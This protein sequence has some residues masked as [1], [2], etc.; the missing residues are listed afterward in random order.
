MKK[1][2]TLCGATAI[3]LAAANVNAIPLSDLFGGGSIEVG[4]KLFGN[5]TELNNEL[6]PEPGC[7]SGGINTA[8]I[9][10]DGVGDGT[11]GN[12]YGL[13]FSGVNGELTQTG[14]SFLDLFFGYSVAVLGGDQV[15][16]GSTMSGT[17]STEGE[18]FLLIVEKDIYESD[19]TD[20]LAFMEIYD[21][22]FDGFMLTDS[23]GF[24]GQDAIWVEDNIFVDG[25][26][27]FAQLVDM[28]Q[29]FIQR[30][31]GQVPEPATLGL[32][33]LGL[34]SLGL[35]QRRRQSK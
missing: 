13:R 16:V 33:V 35:G 20:D 15:I 3:A 30:D 6:C 26:G 31:V 10:V 8:N 27:G 4:D 12:E 19:Q 22:A 25:F 1:L 29:R 2:L 5:F 32:F 7:V 17:T 24:S 14:D 11:A 28:T 18:D 9:M 23:A 21:D 34:L